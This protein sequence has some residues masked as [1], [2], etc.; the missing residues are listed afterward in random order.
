MCGKFIYILNLFFVGFNKIV[1]RAGVYFADCV[2]KIP[3]ASVGKKIII[4]CLVFKCVT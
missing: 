3:C 1:P 4:R 2:V